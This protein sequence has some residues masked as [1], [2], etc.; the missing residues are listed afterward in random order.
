MFFGDNQ[1][2]DNPVEGL[3]DEMLP[4][5]GLPFDDIEGSN[6]EPSDEKG[7]AV[8]QPRELTTEKL[9]E[10]M[11]GVFDIDE[12]IEAELLPARKK[13][14]SG[15]GA[16]EPIL[17]DDKII[18][19]VY[20]AH[21]QSKASTDGILVSDQEGS[22]DKRIDS[23][24]IAVKKRTGSAHLVE[25]DAMMDLLITEERLTRLWN[26]IDSAQKEIPEKIP[27]LVL[28]RE[29]LEQ[30]ERARN[31]VLGGRENF[32]EAERTINEI[33]LRI[34]ITKRSQRDNWAALALFLY[35]IIWAMAFMIVLY[36]TIQ[37]SN[38]NDT[39]IMLNGSVWGGL[40]G[41]AGALY[42]LWKHSSRDVDF[43]K[44]Y[45]L[46]YISNPIMGIVLGAF[47]FL[48]LKLGLLSLSAGESVQ[49]ISSP[50]IIYLLAFI[51][52]YQQNVAWSIVR[53]IVKVFQLS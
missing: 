7:G 5:R 51:V 24:L 34:A 31:E 40:G 2:N 49:D 12:R 16:A 28:A 19:S 53:R 42:A 13:Q 38:L 45:A 14:D 11:G 27:N 6:G 43:S 50:F 37:A 41:I 17:A 33:E 15:M 44:Q 3:G 10:I 32:E 52:G 20:K 8:N 1:D 36:Q 29:L 26:R 39:A 23:G 22:V 48:V 46:W 18:E 25:E 21:T 9:A 35:E 30:L 4:D 47:V